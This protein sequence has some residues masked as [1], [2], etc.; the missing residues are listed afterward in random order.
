MLVHKPTRPRRPISE[1]DPLEA[2]WDYPQ[3][4]IDSE[5]IIHQHRGQIPAVLL[6]IAGVYTD[7]CDSIPL[8]NQVQRIR[9]RRL[10]GRIFPGDIARGQAFVHLDDLVDAFA[11]TVER[12]RDLPAE[13]PILIGEPETFSYDQ[14]QRRI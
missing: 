13:I 4:K 11:R 5:N 8:A 12:R 10:T 3:S 14:L 2:R 1:D 9:E 6:R 7:D